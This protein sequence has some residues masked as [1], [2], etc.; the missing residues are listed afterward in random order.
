MKTN[1]NTLGLN[2]QEL[3]LQSER[4]ISDLSFYTDEIRF[5]NKLHKL[6]F[7]EMVANQSLTVIEDNELR[8]RK[9]RDICEKLSYT[10]KSHLRQL[11][12]V[13]NNNGIGG[14]SAREI[15]YRLEREI[16]SFTQSFKANR[17]AIFSTTR[18]VLKNQKKEEVA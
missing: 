9:A 14:S 13:I 16:K 12:V 10:S 6:Y 2:W 18:K 1:D 7:S 11:A 5:L 15:H 3:Y 4:W 8:F 17:K